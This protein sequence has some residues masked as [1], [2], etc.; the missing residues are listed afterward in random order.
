MQLHFMNVSPQ[1]RRVLSISFT[2]FPQCTNLIHAQPVFV[3][4]SITRSE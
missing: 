2:Y 3:T 1:L 4:V